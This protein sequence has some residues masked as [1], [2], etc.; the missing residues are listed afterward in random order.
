MAL[1]L[2]P[3]HLGRYRDIARLL[4]RHGRSDLV[5]DLGVEGL[6]D[7]DLNQPVCEDAEQLATDLEAL[8]P[9]FIKLGQLLSTRVDLLPKPYTD[10]LSRLQ[11]D[12]AAIPFEQVE[13][14]VTDELGVDLR[15]AFESFDETPLAAA[16]LAQVHH[17]VLRSGREVAVK[18]QRPGI[19]KQI[20]DDLS[21]LAELARFAD[22]H[23]SFG[24]RFGLSDLL[25]QFRKALIAELDYT[26]EA[27]NLITLSRIVAPWPRLVVPQPVPDYST[28][29]VLTMDFL[30]G[31]KVTD[32]T[33][34]ARTDLDG[35]PLVDDLFSAYLQ[36]ILGEGFFHADP[37]PGNV[38]LTADGRLALLDVGMVA[39]LTTS[40]RD[41]CVK[42][43]LAVSDGNG[44][45]AAEAFASLGTKHDDFD[46][47]R[48]R[49]STSDLV[50]RSVDLGHKLQAGAVVL[51]MTRIAGQCG[52][53]PAPEMAMVGKALLN[54][55]QVAQS[56]DPSFAPAEA[57]R[58]N[59]AAILQTRMTTSTG[60]MLGAVLEARDFTV[61]LPGRINKVMDAVGEG[62]FQLKVD[63][64][65]EPQLLAV[66]QRLAN[67]LA[68]GMVV[69]SLV[70]GAALM[71][72]VPTHSRIFGY[73]SVAMVC[74]ALAAA[75]GVALLLSVLLADRRIS[76]T[77]KDQRQKR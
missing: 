63:A 75:G 49:I 9:T 72:Q 67:R 77:A 39:R 45:A 35:A 15:H 38:L 48:F 53:R 59:T 20:T 65:D 50:L 46:A 13:Q 73:P 18:V 21:A 60:G 56:L 37:H 32:L 52:L 25:E 66:L 14:V 12:V 26:R 54:L 7:V 58:R 40:A 41:T 29:R 34:L 61:Q 76:R 23:T 3:R 19:R 71:M 33:P 27:T 51:E 11:D 70:V 62:K 24:R 47:D 28:S 57:I 68:S 10:A 31:R 74:F 6:E 43:L 22:D 44:E 36:Q 16:S 64:I 55:D 2:Q 30:P 17:A 4:I 5:K 8:G 1:S 69:A 42:L